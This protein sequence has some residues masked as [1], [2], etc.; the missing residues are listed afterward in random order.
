MA[1]CLVKVLFISRPQL[2]LLHVHSQT[3]IA[4]M[5]KDMNLCAKYC[6]KCIS[7]SM[8]CHGKLEPYPAPHNFWGSVVRYS[9]EPIAVYLILFDGKV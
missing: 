1:L 3:C 5:C 4:K 9:N 2:L 7:L 8:V 6:S